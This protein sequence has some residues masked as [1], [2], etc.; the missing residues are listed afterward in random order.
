MK[1]REHLLLGEPL[2]DEEIRVAWRWIAHFYY[3]QSLRLQTRRLLEANDR[4]T[5]QERKQ[6]QQIGRREP[7]VDKLRSP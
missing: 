5:Q 1:A 4:P 2:A 6:L 3:P 7:P